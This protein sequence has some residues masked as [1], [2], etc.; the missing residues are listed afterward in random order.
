MSLKDRIGQKSAALVRREPLT[1]PQIGEK[2]M[3]RGMMSGDLLRVN[4]QKDEQKRALLT[5]ALCVE[6]PDTGQLLWMPHSQEDLDH[7]GGLHQ[8]DLIA[9][10]ELAARLSGLAD[11]PEQLLGNSPATQS[12]STS[13]ASASAA[14]PESSDSD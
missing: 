12:S 6:D 4:A 3:V 5:A 2:V 10:A 13:S 11:K 1:L 8:D 14:S 9:I 7:I